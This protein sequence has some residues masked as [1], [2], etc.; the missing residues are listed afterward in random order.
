MP[1]LF[2]AQPV[3]ELAQCDKSKIESLHLYSDRL[4]VGLN[5]SVLRVYRVSE[6]SALDRASSS[7]DS[8]SSLKRG[9]TLELLHKEEAFGKKPI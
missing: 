3:Y 9:E 7:M 2:K 6:T 1:P 4:L 5:T 8:F